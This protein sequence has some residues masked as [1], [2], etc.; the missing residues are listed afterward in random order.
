MTKA[1]KDK[2]A[3]NDDGDLALDSS[4]GEKKGVSA[5]FK[6]EGKAEDVP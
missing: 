4:A 1:Q 2:A 5:I 3:K 6:E